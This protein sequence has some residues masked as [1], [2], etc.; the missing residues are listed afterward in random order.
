[1]GEGRPAAGLSA[2]VGRPGILKVLI[3][4]P[5]LFRPTEHQWAE[6]GSGF[7]RKSKK[8][9]ETLTKT[10]TLGTMRPTNDA[11]Q[12]GCGARSGDFATGCEAGKRTRPAGGTRVDDARDRVKVADGA[13]AARRGTRSPA[14]A[15]GPRVSVAAL[16]ATARRSRRTSPGTSRR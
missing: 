7:G 8:A 16:R 9:P 15:A 11:D 10:A 1:M 12:P 6:I 2:F 5:S 4:R 13:A 3:A 14:A